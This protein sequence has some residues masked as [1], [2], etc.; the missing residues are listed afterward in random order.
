M[1]RFAF[2]LASGGVWFA[3]LTQSSLGEV[4]I[5]QSMMVAEVTKASR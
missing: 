3:L 5:A 4:H 1:K 2:S